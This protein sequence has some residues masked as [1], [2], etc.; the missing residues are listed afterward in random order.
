MIS[1]PTKALTLWQPWA[2]LV[3]NGLKPI[4]N[5]PQAF[6][7][8]NFRGEFWIHAGLHVDEAEFDRAAEIA[9]GY[10]VEIPMWSR[11]DTYA[12]G[13]I[14]GRATITGI[15]SPRGTMFHPTTS[16]PWHFPDQYG[17]IVE[18]ASTVAPVKSRGFPGFWPVPAPVL[19]ELRRAA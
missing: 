13:A 16:V 3:S 17:L 9:R 15:I 4:E 19:E 10:G 6:T 7:Q 14:V 5:R 2:W 12:L 8:R 1:L 18:H 11:P